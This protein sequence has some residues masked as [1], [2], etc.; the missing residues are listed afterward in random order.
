MAK[1]KATGTITIR[2]IT[3]IG[4][5]SSYLTSSQPL[6]VVYDPNSTNEYEPN[7]STSKLVLTPVVFFNDAQLSLSASGLSISWQ[8]Q[9]G[10]GEVTALTTGETVSGNVLTVSKNILADTSMIT[11]ICNI[12]YVDP[13]T[14]GVAI[15]SRSQMSFS[16]VKNAPKLSDCNVTGDTV[17]KYNTS[18]TLVSASSIT[19]TANL[20]NTTL[21]Q[22]QYK[23]SDGSFAEY[24][25]STT[26]VTLTVK[27]SDN[28]FVNDVAVIKLVTADNNVF[29]L[30]TIVKLRDG[31]AG[32]STITCNLSNDTQSVPCNSAGTLYSTSLNG[33]D[34][35]ISVLKG[36]TN[37]TANWNI[38]A[39]PSS[40]IAGTYDSKTYKYTVTGITVDSG[41]V[42][43][44]CTRSGYVT[45]T[46]RFTI[47]KDR[48]GSDGAAAVF[49]S[50]NSD[51]AFMKLNKSK[52]F[53]PSSITFSATRTVGN[54]AA[55]VYS[56]RYKIYESTDG[57][58]YTLKYTSSSDEQSKQY[59]PSANTVM[60][61]KCELYQAGNTTKLLDS[62]TVSVVIDGTDGQTGAAGK[63]AVNVVLGNT[64]EVIPCTSAGAAKSAK[65]IT[66]PFDCYQG[67]KRIAGTAS[68]GTLPSGVTLKSNTAATASAGGS[69]V[70]TV[71]A[72]ATIS[73]ANSGDITITFT[74]AGLTSV[75][76]FTWTKSIQAN[77]GT[78]AIL[79]QLMA[80]QGDVILKNL[81]DNVN[82]VQLKSQL[83]NGTTIVTSGI[84]YVW[85]KYTNGSYTTIPG[86][87]ASTLTVTADMVDSVASFECTAT[88]GGK[89][90]VA[91]W[92]V[93]DK[94]DAIS[95]DV[96]STLG[97]TFV[98]S[99]GVGVIYAKI[100]QNNK[101]YDELKT[102]VFSTTAPSNPA[103][104]DFYY[105]LDA[106]AKTATLMK[107][108]GSAWKAASGSDL[109]KGTYSW[110]R[111]DKDG[112]ALD[113]TIPYKTGKVIFSNGSIVDVKTI[114]DCEV[115]IEI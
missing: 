42:E 23:K 106:S 72:G 30:H 24:P 62:Q 111:R 110:Y 25:N 87:T 65:N 101:E 1:V 60:T 57:S 8:R 31:A 45:I 48:S 100:M 12:S 22:W 34:T 71:A 6:M 79:F 15:K 76:K 108:D 70:L 59:T 52:V 96:V 7:W 5:I 78:N 66:I 29:D 18:G 46:K 33:C 37:D 109:P 98:N 82:S 3:N 36:S 86:Q 67:T 81:D 97:D 105:K 16:L 75:Q 89:S 92:T 50:V 55:A 44:I 77:N 107:Y 83:L 115:E 17:F 80:P 91:Y 39:T 85:K 99:K 35:T 27:A 58:T 14:N 40:G 54:N 112:K 43:F 2:N 68:L 64:A 20:T 51:V 113:T 28:V 74:A 84:T 88:Y 11:Y 32:S 47:N 61:I 21:K 9:A 90:Y 94:Q 19:L 95:I 73:S 41:Y 114:F 102:D 49:Y 103:S 10:A 13:N 104:G 38:T 69:I 63:D 56:G 26:A 93:T 4:K 53:T